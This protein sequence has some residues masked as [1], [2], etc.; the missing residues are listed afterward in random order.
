MELKRASESWRELERERSV[1]L[2]LGPAEEEGCEHLENRDHE[3]DENDQEHRHQHRELVA[4]ELLQMHQVV[5][6]HLARELGLAVLSLREED[7]HL[8]VLPHRALDIQLQ[9]DL[10]PNGADFGS[11][12]AERG[13]GDRE[14]ARHGVGEGG[15]RAR[16]QPRPFGYHHTVPGPRRVDVKPDAVPRAQGEV[17][18]LSQALEQQRHLLGGVLEVS[19]HAHHALALAFLEPAEHR[20]REPALARAHNDPDRIALL[21]KLLHRFFAAI[22]GVVIHDDKLRLEVQRVLLERCEQ[23]LRQRSDVGV[24]LEAG[25]TTVPV[26]FPMVRAL[27]ATASFPPTAQAA[28]RTSAKAR[29]TAPLPATRIVS[30][31]PAGRPNDREL[32]QR[33][34]LT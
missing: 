21:A 12:A 31:S 17:V 5:Q 13:L 9:R 27:P 29:R 7:A 18:A 32:A 22:A 30:V 28:E 25:T 2:G 19:V 26:I 4:V 34:P 6:H 10:E 20:R 16:E 24:L 8:P 15:E 23:A 3:A 33:L 14:E 11:A 1:D